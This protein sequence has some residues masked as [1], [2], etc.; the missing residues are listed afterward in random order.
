M[1]EEV[2]ENKNVLFIGVKF[3]EYHLAIK[4]KMEQYGA[5]VSFFAER[6]TSILYGI[7]NRLLPQRIDSFQKMHYESILKAI[8]KKKFDYL[9]VVR[10]YRMPLSFVKTV[11]ARNPGIKTIMYQWDANVNSAYLNLDEEY[12]LIPEFDK[13]FSFDYKDVEQNPWIKYSP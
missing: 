5:A 9:L 12:N 7:V 13:V 10:G 8:A 2:F 1:L 11:K 3:Y 6:D 4:Q